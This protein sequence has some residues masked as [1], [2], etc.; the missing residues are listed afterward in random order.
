MRERLPH[1]HCL[2]LEM[3]WNARETYW[4]HPLCT[5]FSR[6]I[7]RPWVDR[8]GLAILRQLASRIARAECRIL[9]TF[10][11]ERTAAGARDHAVRRAG[12]RV[13]HHH[14]ARRPAKTPERDGG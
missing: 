9:A 1:L 10:P 2:A 12:L 11:H 3:V 4:G 14:S 6:R 13:L 8:S 5:G 7:C